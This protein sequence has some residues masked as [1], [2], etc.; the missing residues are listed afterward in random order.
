MNVV[1]NNADIRKEINHHIRNCSRL[2]WAIAWASPSEAKE[3]NLLL[4]HR[5][6]IDQLVV[7]T[8][9][10]Q[11]APNFVEAFYKHHRVRFWP[12]TDG[13]FHPKVYLFFHHDQ[14]CDAFI[15]SANFTEAAMS[16]NHEAM[17]H[18]SSQD[19]GA[20]QAIA[21][22][23]ATIDNYW[24]NAKQLTDEDVRSY[25]ERYERNRKTI[26][27]LSG[28]YRGSRE[29]SAKLSHGNLL[30][31]TWPDYY[32]KVRAEKISDVKQPFEERLALLDHAK[33]AFVKHECFEHIPLQDRKIVGGFASETQQQHWRLFGSTQGAGSFKS[34]I[35]NGDPRLS[36]ALA[37]IPLHG[38]CSSEALQTFIYDFRRVFGRDGLGC[39][40]RLLAL[41]RPDLFLCVNSP[42]TVRLAD[43]VGI[44]RSSLSGP[45]CWDVY[46][47][48]VLPFLRDCP[49]YVS[50][51]PTGEPELSA[52]CA[53]MALVDS[54]LYA[55]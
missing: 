20:Q 9:F 16:R 12:T 6:K 29:P 5:E 23:Q 43:A 34:L 21:S 41:R 18:I 31:L 55:P 2:S 28:T 10:Y 30:N 25:R 39:G 3:L 46:V 11:T 24:E 35:A 8:H 13:V 4:Q 36:A 50:E 32:R 54:L 48:A 1:T 49:W 52:W 14:T 37:H 40:T 44:S 45:N 27:R 47:D 22:L 33:E 38:E 42:N 53:R 26:M 7:G 19:A 15:G 17:L 51:K